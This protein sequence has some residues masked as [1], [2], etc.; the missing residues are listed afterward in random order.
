MFVVYQHRNK[1]NGKVY[2]GIT[3]K[4]PEKRWG[5]NGNGYRSSPYFHSAILKYGWDNFEHNV[6]FVDLT[7]EE[8]CLKEQELIR[9]FKSNDRHFGYNQTSGGDFFTLSVEAKDKISRGMKGNKNGL[10]HPCSREK[11]EKISKAQKG[12]H[13]A[14]DHRQ[15]LSEASKKRHVP[16][17][18]EKRR[19]LS[20]N[21][22][23]KRKVYCIELDKVFESVQS[24]GKS[25]G[26]PPTNITKLCK[27]RGK[28]LRG[29]HF[30]YI[31][32]T[33]NAERLSTENV[34]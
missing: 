27:G 10:E 34:E 1:V 15:K 31:N 13:L 14:Q 11:A 12:K 5:V 22:P 24:C 17:S 7:R 8:A 4:S 3:S 25:L 16:C 6:L 9:E 28:S 18:Y 2:I 23:H 30:E 32:D 21:Y 26:I 33:V 19:T 20:R 29:L